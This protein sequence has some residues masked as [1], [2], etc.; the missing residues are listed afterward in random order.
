[1][2]KQWLLRWRRMRRYEIQGSL[3]DLWSLACA[4]R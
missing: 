1:M 4:C 3:G 2:V